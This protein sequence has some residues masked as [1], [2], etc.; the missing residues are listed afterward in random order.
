[1]NDYF[2]Y[3][4]KPKSSAQTLE[5]TD[6]DILKENWRFVRSED[7]ND[8]STWE[9]RMAKKYY[10]KLFKEFCIADMTYYEQGKVKFYLFENLPFFI[11]YLFLFFKNK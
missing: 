7:D 5:K 2:H 8:G 9:K 3:Y 4:G 6:Y 1:M 10:D 11:Y